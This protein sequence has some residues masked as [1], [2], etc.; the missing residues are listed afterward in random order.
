MINTKKVLLI[1][2]AILIPVITIVSSVYL[3]N[4]KEEDVKG[5]SEKKEVC[6]PSVTNMIPNVANV[7]DVY[8]FAPRIVGCDEEEV[9]IT[10]EGAEWLSVGEGRYIYG[11][12]TKS[13]VGINRV[14]LTVSSSGSSSK[15]IEYIVVE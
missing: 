13:D 6:T 10:I 11:T 5:V 12:P 7:G 4:K 1:I 15:Y 14:V 9:E 3:L 8:Y 2:F